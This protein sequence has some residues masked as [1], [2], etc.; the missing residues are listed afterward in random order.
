MKPLTLGLVTHL[1]TLVGVR[2]MRREE[3][4]WIKSRS[5]ID[6]EGMSHPLRAGQGAPTGALG[7]RAGLRGNRR[8][9]LSL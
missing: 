6:L 4:Q 2:D 1:S 7:V 3:N 9:T 5:R 8:M